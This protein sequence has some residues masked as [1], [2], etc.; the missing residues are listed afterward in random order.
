MPDRHFVVDPSRII[1]T[2]AMRSSDAFFGSAR[3][4]M[5]LFLQVRAFGIGVMWKAGIHDLEGMEKMRRVDL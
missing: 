3:R 2:S 1:L 4:K 5:N